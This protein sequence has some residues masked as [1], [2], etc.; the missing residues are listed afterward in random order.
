MNLM[1]N[2]LYYKEGFTGAG[3]WEMAT[4]GIGLYVADTFFSSL[5]YADEKNPELYLVLLKKG[6]PSMDCEEYQ[7]NAGKDHLFDQMPIKGAIC[8]DEENGW[9]VLKLD[10]KN[11]DMWTL[12]DALVLRGEAFNDLIVDIAKHIIGMEKRKIDPN[13]DNL[14][15]VQTLIGSLKKEN[16]L[17]FLYTSV[18]DSL[19]EL[20]LDQGQIKNIA[21]VLNDAFSTARITD[22]TISGKGDN[23][24]TAKM[25]LSANL[26]N[27]RNLKIFPSIISTLETINNL[28]A[29]D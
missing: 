27:L 5:L 8:F 11:F 17:N 19:K 13:L 29:K 4:G 1:N 16:G 6:A 7:K 2:R 15:S 23:L 26:K 12:K 14:A 21:L 22:G 3:T 20:P 18:E 25:K 10:K 9:W 28:G 24:I